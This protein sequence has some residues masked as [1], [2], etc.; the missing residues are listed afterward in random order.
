MGLQVV[1]H[2]LMAE[3]H[4]LITPLRGGERRSTGKLSN[5]PLRA[6][7]LGRFVHRID[8]VKDRSLRDRFQILHEVLVALAGAARKLDVMIR[9]ES[10]RPGEDNWILNL[11]ILSL[12]S[13][14]RQSH[15]LN[16]LRCEGKV[17]FKRLERLAL[18]IWDMVREVIF[19]EVQTRLTIDRVHGDK[20]GGVSAISEEFGTHARS[21]VDSTWNGDSWFGN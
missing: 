8:L 6:S 10:E 15:R 18:C 12:C 16:V 19:E 3:E 17:P 11:S 2:P 9:L 14:I 7:K 5:Q 1:V 13:H 20:V 21:Q 4:V